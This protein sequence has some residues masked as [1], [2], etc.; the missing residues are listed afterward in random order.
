M[1]PPG[2]IAAGYLVA[3]IIISA[4]KPAFSINEIN[5][6]LWSGAFFG[7]APDLDMFYAFW[8]VKSFR[9]SGEKFNHRQF[10]THT[11]IIWL[12]AGLFVALLGRTLFWK[13]LGIIICL[14]AWSHLFLDSFY[15]GVRWLYPFNK[16][17]YAIKQAGINETNVATGFFNHWWNLIKQYYQH[18][19]GVLY[20]EIVLILLALIVV[21][22]F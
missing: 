10:I 6:L 12:S 14:S 13:Y 3:K 11:P 20:T 8:K 22:S 17:F 16:K 4:T 9:H 2:H 5:W 18:N 1:L 21:L 19:T 15:M 7:F